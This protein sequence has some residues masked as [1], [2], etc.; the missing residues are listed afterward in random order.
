MAE[1]QVGFS[2]CHSFF[3]VSWFIDKINLSYLM[4]QQKDTSF[5]ASE[6]KNYEDNALS[7]LNL[8]T[9]Y[10]PFYSGNA[11]TELSKWVGLV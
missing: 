10:A 4:E 5:I 11:K 6:I 9:K 8:H 2:S 3:N 7:K 1:I